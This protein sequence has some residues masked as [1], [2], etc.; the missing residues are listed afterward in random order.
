MILKHHG[1]CF[2]YSLCENTSISASG[3]IPLTWGHLPGRTDRRRSC[4]TATTQCLRST[5]SSLSPCPRTT[6]SSAA[7]TALICSGPGGRISISITCSCLS[8]ERKHTQAN[9]VSSCF[10]SDFYIP[11]KVK[12]ASL[13]VILRM[14]I[15]IIRPFLTLAFFLCLLSLICL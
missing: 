12:A 5:S 15:W 7:L 10:G 9:M 14:V 2:L 11:V 4:M 13:N 3:W 1:E 8:C 6:A